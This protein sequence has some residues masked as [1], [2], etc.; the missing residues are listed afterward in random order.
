MEIKNQ[1][2]NW[3]TKTNSKLEEKAIRK[4][5]NKTENGNKK[6]KKN[7]TSMSCEAT[8]SCPM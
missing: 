3:W 8:S 1:L 2:D 7:R 6:E 4:H 5:Q